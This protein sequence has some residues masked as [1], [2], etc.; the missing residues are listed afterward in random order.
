[1]TYAFDKLE[2]EY[3]R[4]NPDLIDVGEFLCPVCRRPVRMRNGSKGRCYFAHGRS[5]A[6]VERRCKAR[7]KDVLAVV[8]AEVNE[9]V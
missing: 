6:G 2:R 4:A 8:V 5:P 9:A 3:V 7:D 1:M